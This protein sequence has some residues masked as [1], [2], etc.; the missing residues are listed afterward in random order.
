M[1][2]KILIHSNGPTV[3]TGYG[4]QCA[5][6]AERLADAGYEV[7]V[8]CTF[9][10]QGSIGTWRTPSG[11]DVRLYPSA[12]LDQG[13]D[14]ISAHAM[15]WF[16]GDHD[17]GIIIPLLDVW[18]LHN[19]D[20]DKFNVAA[21][22]P[23]DH[24]PV[25]PGVLR[26]FE[27]TNATPVAMSRF[28]ERLFMEAG[29]SPTYIPLAVDTK[30]LRPRPTITIGDV[31]V[32]GRQL[33]G[34]PKDAF[35]VGMVAMNKGWSR[36]RKGF[37]EAFRAFGVFWKAHQE[38]V[39]LVHADAAG[40][41]EGIDLHELARHAGIPPHALVFT[42]QYAYRMGV[43]QVQMAA[44][45]STFDVLLSPSHG[46]GFC[47]PLIEAQACGTPVIATD[48]S[49][50]PELFLDN[51]VTG[52]TVTGQP[53]WDPAQR[54]SYVVPFI[55]DVVAKLELAYALADDERQAMSERCVRFAANYDADRV[56]EECWLPF[57]ES[58]E[59]SKQPVPLERQPMQS[60]DVI[61]PLVRAANEER[62]FDSFR[63]TA[64]QG[65]RILPGGDADKTYAQNVNDCYARST[66][67]FV[68][69][70][71]D[72]VE[73]KPG[74]FEAAQKLS[75]RYDVIGTNDTDGAPK[76]LDVA[77]GRHADHFFVRRSYIEEYGASLEGPGILAPEVYRHWWVDKEIVELA[78][79]RNVFTP[80]LDS[81]I[82]HHQPGYDGDE[83]ARAAD[84]LYAKAVESAE[85]DRK[86]FLSRA[87]LIAAQ[88]G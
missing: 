82:V 31:E 20:L 81:V 12:Y 26:F 76:N 57:L 6:L 2:K 5:L 69:V 9:G 37:N 88:R 49:A 7:A 29:L 78:K 60:V 11:K 51:G 42:D 38:A 24:F 66:A 40:A 85:Q 68:L 48:F 32:S 17:K 79:A 63:A 56:F 13:N 84:P 8:S 67:D 16:D 45:Y 14:V 23:V 53:E 34:V 1:K 83:A 59:R 41:A 18:A 27:R 15:Q 50:Q 77:A 55:A 65:V 64:P 58:F 28:G 71:G 75:D 52:W 80:C 47:V 54:A 61:V 73:F 70:V 30:V 25:P 4:V 10:Q 62:L 87:P 19:P 36:D 43:T 44:L 21:W 72:D 74:W 35:V 33:Y 22:A 3:K 86:T 46:E 39:L